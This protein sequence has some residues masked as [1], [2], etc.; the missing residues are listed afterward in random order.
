M[1]FLMDTIMENVRNLQNF[2]NTHQDKHIRMKRH[3]AAK[4]KKITNK[5]PA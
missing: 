1:F 4:L 5:K 3:C 2:L